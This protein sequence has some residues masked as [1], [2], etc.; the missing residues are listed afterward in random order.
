IRSDAQRAE[1]HGLAAALGDALCGVLFDAEGI[2]ALRTAMAP[3]RPRP[4]ITLRSND[5]ALLALPWELIRLDGAYLVR[6]GRVDLARSVPRDVGPG[7]TLPEPDGPLSLVVNV[8][9]PEGGGL[10]YEAESYRITRALAG[11]CT[12]EPTE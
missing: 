1:L 12:M 7:A 11:R 10:N 3:G 9:A 8:S 4:L 2:D 5:D 6:D